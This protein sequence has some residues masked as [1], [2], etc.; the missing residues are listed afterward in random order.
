MTADITARHRSDPDKVVGTNEE[1][2]KRVQEYLEHH[3]GKPWF[4]SAQAVQVTGYKDQWVVH[5]Y[6]RQTAPRNAVIKN[7]EQIGIRFLPASAK[8]R[9]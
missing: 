3:Q 6:C 2:A 4:D 1:R 7:R 8:S 9:Y 5:V